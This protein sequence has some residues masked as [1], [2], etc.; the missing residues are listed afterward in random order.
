MPTQQIAPRASGF[1]PVFISFTTL[2]FRPIAPMAMTIRNLL[3]I[4]SGSNTLASTPADTT[5]VVIKEATTKYNTNIGNARFKLNEF[6]ASALSRMLL[7]FL[8]V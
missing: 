4:L 8:A 7:F 1:P 2:L 5:I 6:P 3:S